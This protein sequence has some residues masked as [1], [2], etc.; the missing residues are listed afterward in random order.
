MP[1]LNQC[2]D[3]GKKREDFEMPA[4]FSISGGGICVEIVWRERKA[5]GI[6]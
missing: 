4:Y 1:E 2:V 5:T 6:H 3:C